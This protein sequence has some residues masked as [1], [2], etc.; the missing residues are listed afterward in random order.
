MKFSKASLLATCVPAVAARFIEKV[1][2]D[3]I[4]LRPDETFLVETAPGKTQWVTEDE[5]WEMRRVSEPKSF[6]S[7]I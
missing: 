3:N 1:E 5:K 2:A 6:I 7:Y 4:V